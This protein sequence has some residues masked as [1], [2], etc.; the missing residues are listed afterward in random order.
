LPVGVRRH[1]P[2]CPGTRHDIGQILSRPILARLAKIERVAE[3][4]ACA[5]PG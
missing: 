1:R 4:L 3:E 5:A 2:A